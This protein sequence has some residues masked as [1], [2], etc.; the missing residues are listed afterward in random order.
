MLSAVA[1]IVNRAGVLLRVV[2]AKR[3]SFRHHA[4]TVEKI[5]VVPKMRVQEPVPWH[6]IPAL[7]NKVER[8]VAKV[9]PPDNHCGECR[10]C[11]TTAEVIDTDAG[12]SKPAHTPC[13]HLCAKGC[14][15]YFD[16]PTACKSY[17]CMWLQS[18]GTNREMPAEMRPDRSGVIFSKNDY[19][20]K[21]LFICVVKERPDA[22]EAD[23]VKNFIERER[24]EGS[25][26]EIV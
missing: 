17:K 13:M 20:D 11:C 16:R 26:P 7:I 22:L 21:R 9:Y 5:V 2:V 12:F 3:S 14:S 8:H 15:V 10:Q 4:S 23:L 19:D 1:G 24:E 25:C 18:Q 6:E